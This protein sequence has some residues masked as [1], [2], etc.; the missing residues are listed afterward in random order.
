MNAPND[1]QF[2]RRGRHFAWLQFGLALGIT[3]CAMTPGLPAAEEASDP[4]VGRNTANGQ[5]LGCVAAFLNSQP[6]TAAALRNSKISGDLGKLAAA[7]GY[8]GE[9][10]DLD[11]L[12][13]LSKKFK[14]QPVVNRDAIIML[15]NAIASH[16]NELRPAVSTFTTA[17]KLR[18]QGVPAGTDIYRQVVE[19]K[20]T[21]LSSRNVHET[22]DGG[23]FEVVIRSLL[24]N[25]LEALYFLEPEPRDTSTAKTF[26]RD[27]IK[28]LNDMRDRISR[29]QKQQY[30]TIKQKSSRINSNRFWYASIL[31]ALGDRD[32]LRN[33]LRKF[34]TERD[35]FDLQTKNPGHIYIYNVFNLPYPIILKSDGSV[36]IKELNVVNRYFNPRQLALVACA[37]LDEAGPAGIRKFSD[38]INRVAFSDY[39]VIGAT[40]AKPEQLEKFGQALTRVIDDN[41]DLRQKREQMLKQV[42]AQEID[43]FRNAIMRGAQLCGISNDVRDRIYSTFEFRPQI[44]HFDKVVK[45]PYQ[46]VFGTRVNINQAKT[47]ADFLN[48]VIAKSPQLQAAQKELGADKAY[49]ARMQLDQ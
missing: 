36:E 20:H 38:A 12:K 30:L 39:Y 47:I 45:L 24:A 43:G 25:S 11:T 15:D 10:E 44:E 13:R 37:H 4:C 5:L 40:A 46:L 35:E 14:E 34:V 2:K 1:R 29:P 42:T 18:S 6:P 23:P 16:T 9:A 31:F 21:F 27:E 48:E 26:L 49:F 7:S 22:Y 41:V 3:V 17:H 28:I 33:E 8:L 19:R 32:N